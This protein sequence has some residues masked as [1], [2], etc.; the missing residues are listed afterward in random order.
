MRSRRSVSWPADHKYFVSHALSSWQSLPG[1][2]TSTRTTTQGGTEE[3]MSTSRCKFS[4][5]RNS[6]VSSLASSVKRQ[7]IFNSL[8]NLV[9]AVFG[10]CRRTWSMYISRLAH[11]GEFSRDAAKSASHSPSSSKSRLPRGPAVP[12]PARGL[13][14]FS[15]KERP[16]YTLSPWRIG[17]RSP[18]FSILPLTPTRPAS[19]KRRMEVTDPAP[20]S[21]RQRKSGTPRPFRTMVLSLCAPIVVGDDSLIK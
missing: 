7:V 15:T 19:P 10:I 11:D 9:A 6:D 16:R 2:K 20:C 1:G 3:V 17:S 4:S 14:S 21:M 12:A 8:R 18:V 5:L 13:T